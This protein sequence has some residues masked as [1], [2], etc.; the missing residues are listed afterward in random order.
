MSSRWTELGTDGPGD[1]WNLEL[2][3]DRACHGQKD[4]SKLD[5]V[6]ARF[7]E[8]CNCGP[9]HSQKCRTNNEPDHDALP[10]KKIMYIHL[11]L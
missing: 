11:C 10:P 4:R 8:L 3:A 6:R 2:C 7:V 5:Q 1:G 9:G